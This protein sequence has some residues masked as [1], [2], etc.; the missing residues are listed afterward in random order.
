VVGEGQGAAPVAHVGAAGVRE[1]LAR[2][3]HLYGEPGI[4]GVA[5]TLAAWRHGEDWLARLRQ[6]LARNAALV[7]DGLPAG[8]G[9]RMPQATFLAWLDCREPGLEPD[10]YTFFRDEAR[11][12]L[13]DGRAF[14][15]GGE[16][17]VRL[18]FATSRDILEDILR[19]IRES[20]T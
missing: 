9:Y 7:R 12:L 11:V 19:R 13:H 5:A 16:G 17:F 15:P 1:A 10:P 3:T 6:V 20:L 2:P 4:F 14:G 8:V 18:N